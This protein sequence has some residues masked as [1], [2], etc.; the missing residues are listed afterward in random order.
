MKTLITLT[1]ILISIVSFAQVKDAAAT[2]KKI[3]GNWR[4]DGDTTKTMQ[5]INNKWS[6]SK[7]F[8]ASA[9]PTDTY[10]VTVRDNIKLATKKLNAEFI[11]LGNGKDTL[12]YEVLGLFRTTISL[13]QFPSGKPQNYNRYKGAVK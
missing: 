6:F 2:I 7:N 5:V 12:Y 1:S 8:E 13:M 9:K 4:L 11:V 10:E 3:Q